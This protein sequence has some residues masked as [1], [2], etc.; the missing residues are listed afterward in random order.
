MKPV[1][2]VTKLMEVKRADFASEHEIAMAV[3]AFLAN[4]VQ[5]LKIE[6]PKE[7][8]PAQFPNE[9]LI[10]YVGVVVGYQ[11]EI[12]QDAIKDAHLSMMLP[13]NRAILS[14]LMYGPGL[15]TALGVPQSYGV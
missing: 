11:G 5:A 15:V 9:W 3:S 1:E 12:S 6:L 7:C 4:L 10:F 14:R 13:S 8:V 2:L